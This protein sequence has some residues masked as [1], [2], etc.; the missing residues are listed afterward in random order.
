MDENRV[1]YCRRAF[2]DY[3]NDM[4]GLYNHVRRVG[5]EAQDKL[6][7]CRSRYERMRST[8]ESRINQHQRELSDAEAD[9]RRAGSRYE[10]AARDA[11]S[12]DPRVQAAA[13]RE[14][15]EARQAEMEARHRAAKAQAQLTEARSMELRLNR[16]W[17]SQYPPARTVQQKM[18]AALSG[19]S[20]LRQC[21]QKDLDHY[22]ELMEKARQVLNEYAFSGVTGRTG[23][24]SSTSGTVATST[25]EEPAAPLPANLGWCARNSMNAVRVDGSGV[26]TVTMTI[27]GE[28]RTYTCDRKG[29][30]NAYRDANRFRDV[31][32]L[33]VT[34]AMFEIE[35]LRANLDLTTGMAGVPQLGGYHRDVKV[36]DGEGY[37]SHHIPAQSVQSAAADWLPTISI[38]EDDHALTPSYRGKSKHVYESFVPH[39]GEKESY[40]NLVSRKVSSGSA[41]YIHALKSEVLELRDCVG[42]KYDGGISAFLDAVLDMLST[43]GIP[44]AK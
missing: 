1:T 7:E 5:D 4:N 9:A 2:A 34:S 14:M 35:D 28:S 18:E 36:Q 3:Q 42:H 6:R 10:Q 22:G 13:N 43:R 39:S 25:R 21:A 30:A 15:A 24:F 37:E 31:D 27:G 40:R 38:T 8:L 33:A 20:H 41:G 32:M 16:F 26:K 12:E 44:E 11:S 23:S 29:M 17:D 19:F